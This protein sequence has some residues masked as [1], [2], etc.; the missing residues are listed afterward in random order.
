MLLRLKLLPPTPLRLKLLLRTLL[1][2]LPP[3]TQL[4]LPSP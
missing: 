4:L 2:R 1:P 3:P